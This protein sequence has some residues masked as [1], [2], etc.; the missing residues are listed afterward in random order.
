MRF[1]GVGW[2]GYVFLMGSLFVG[3]VGGIQGQHVFGEDSPA[4]WFTGASALLLYAVTVFVIGILATKANGDPNI[5]GVLPLWASS[6]IYVLGAWI[7]VA[8]GVAD[9]SGHAWPGWVTF[10]A[11]I[12]VSIAAVLKVQRGSL[13]KR[14]RYAR[15]HGWR[16]ERRAKALDD[17]YRGG[18]GGTFGRGAF[19][20][21]SG[22]IDGCPFTAWDS[23]SLSASSGW[24]GEMGDRVTVWAVH[25]PS[26]LPYLWASLERPVA[27]DPE[28][29]G[30]LIGPGT[31]DWM[32]RNDMDGWLIIGSD[33]MLVRTPKATTFS[34]A[35]IE[36][37]ARR[38]VALYRSFPATSLSR[39]PNAERG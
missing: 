29:A 14:R 22:T 36:A 35:E 24:S 33:L 20:V 17:R 16:Y 34:P 11:P 18:P 28:L 9:A 6:W 32:R 10:F 5:M 19:G 23:T 38:L 4:R 25:M 30:R 39:A 12:P 21:V 15:A 8:L 13:S 27:A 31:E 1:S 37:F 2:L 26:P 3:A 7:L